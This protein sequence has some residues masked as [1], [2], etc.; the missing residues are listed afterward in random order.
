[1]AK[2]PKRYLLWGIPI[3]FL[4]GSLFHFLFEFSGNSALV[5]PFAAT[6]ESVFEHTKMVLL[7]I[8]LYWVLYYLIKGKQ[9]NLDPNKWFLGALTSLV[10][11]IVAMPLLF[12]FYTEAFGIES[13]FIDIL[14]LLIVIALGQLM[15]IHVYEH[16]KGTINWKVSLAII[17]LI[18]VMY[19]VFTFNPPKLPLFYDTAKGKYGI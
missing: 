1:M 5:A 19:A 4:I 2:Q 14:L 12:Y 15:G 7:P 6:N 18:F 17:V 8:T 11:S 16:A 9:Y 13:L 10:V 3:L